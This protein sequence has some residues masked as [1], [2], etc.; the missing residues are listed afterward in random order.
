MTSAV[1]EVGPGTVRAQPHQRTIPADVVA[2]ALAGIDDTTVLLGERP[3]SVA[4]LWRQ[5]VEGSIET[6]CVSI[7]VVHPS[8]WSQSQVNRVLDVTATVVD[9]VRAVPR[10]IAIAQDCRATVVEIADDIVAVSAPGAPLAIL[11]R[12]EDPVEIAEKLESPVGAGV[13]LDAP[14]GVA[15]AAE[16]ARALQDVLSRRGMTARLAGPI[17]V[18]EQA[19]VVQPIANSAPRRRHYPMLAAA[20]LTVAVCAGGVIAGRNHAPAPVLD[21]VSI[22]EGHVTVQIPSR[23]HVTRITAGPGSR[24]IQASSLTEP[25]VALHVTQ[26]YSPGETFDQAA[27]ALRQAVAKQPRGVFVDFNSGDRRGGRPAV[28]YR[29]VRPGRDIR[30]AVV[31]DGSTRISIGCQSPS[32]DGD[33]VAEAC[34]KAIESAHEFG[35]NQ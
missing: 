33:I 29:E 24:R 3:V 35:G 15:G 34:E 4:D 8:W 18:S 27:E 25:D 16:Y 23:W 26:S 17:E 28:T 10:S 1:L 21:S 32:G 11:S 30:W 31:L 6:H 12:A 2:A 7:T 14:P 19:P 20:S 5:V 13:L 22:A 9:T